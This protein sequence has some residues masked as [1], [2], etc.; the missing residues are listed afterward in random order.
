MRKHRLTSTGEFKR[1]R[2]IRKN[3]TCIV[4]YHEVR[5]DCGKVFW[6]RNASWGRQKQCKICDCSEKSKTHGLS[7]SLEGRLV[8][9]A[10]KRAVKSEL[11][12]NLVPEDIIIPD[13]CPV[14]GFALDKTVRG[15]H[16]NH[17]PRFN[18]PSLDRINPQLGY[19]KKNVRV[20]SLRAN[21]IKKDGTAE[22]HIKVA[23]FMERMGVTD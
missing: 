13:F 19:I 7:L 21:N 10:K 18:A 4:V 3:R 23:E 9:S 22:E 17:S 8:Y 1:R 20:I 6:L 2:E 15:S 11:D 14:L 5:C 12:F 16:H